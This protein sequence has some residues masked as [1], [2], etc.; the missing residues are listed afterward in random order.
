MKVE[1][2]NKNRDGISESVIASDLETK[3]KYQIQSKAIINATGVF[4]DTVIKMDDP[5]A[6][7]MIQPSQGIH[8]VPDSSFLPDKYAIMVPHTKNGRILFAVPWH[9]K[10]IS[11]T[12]ETVIEKPLLEPHFND[13][14]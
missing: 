10:V 7:E 9:N 1:K 8:I 14:R 11:G 3:E 6:D 12:T 5:D 4:A 13:M 2:I